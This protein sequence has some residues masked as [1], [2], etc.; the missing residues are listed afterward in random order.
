MEPVASIDLVG[1]V[2]ASSVSICCSY[3]NELRALSNQYAQASTFT[4]QVDNK[5][6]NT[7]MEDYHGEI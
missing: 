7:R 1:Q 5:S 6:R 4:A 2:L 3:A